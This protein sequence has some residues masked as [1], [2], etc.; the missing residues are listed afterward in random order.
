[1]QL[2]VLINYAYITLILG[3]I[4]AAAWFFE[5]LGEKNTHYWTISK[6]S[7]KLIAIFGFIVGII[8]IIT[9]YYAVVMNYYD[10]FTIILLAV[11]GVALSLVPITKFPIAELFSVVAGVSIAMLVALIVPPAI[12]NWLYTLFGI[13]AWI[14][15]LI[16]FAIV[17]FLAYIFAKSITG[18]I[19]VIGSILTSKPISIIIGIIA[20]IQGIMLALR[21]TLWIYIAPYL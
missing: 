3:G 4:S 7:N 9:A 8:S 1:M 6:R 14:I 16:V 12:W 5:K 17:A 11:I 18:F 19:E 20:V 10:R 2:V 15:L 21:T 13:K